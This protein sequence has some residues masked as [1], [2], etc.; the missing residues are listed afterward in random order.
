[1][2]LVIILLGSL[3][4]IAINEYFTADILSDYMIANIYEDILL[5]NLSDKDIEKFY[6]LNK[7]EAVLI[8]HFAHTLNKEEFILEY[9]KI[10]YD[11]D[12]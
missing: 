4:V 1:M 3:V 12:L 8:K 9:K 7:G 10:V 2:V 5:H 11:T 6:K